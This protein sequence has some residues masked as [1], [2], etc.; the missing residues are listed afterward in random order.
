MLKE[1]VE[2]LSLPFSI[3][4]PMMILQYWYQYF[5]NITFEQLYL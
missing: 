4:D 3:C 1:G 5:V 2:K